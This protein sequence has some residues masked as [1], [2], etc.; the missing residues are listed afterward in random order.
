MCDNLEQ[1]TH[2]ELQEGLKSMYNKFMKVMQDFHDRK[3]IDTGFEE[4]SSA[5]DWAARRVDEP[6]KKKL[7]KFNMEL[8]KSDIS[9]LVGRKRLAKL[10]REFAPLLKSLKVGMKFEQEKKM[11]T[12]QQYVNEAYKRVWQTPSD[13]KNTP[14]QPN[15]YKNPSNPIIGWFSNKHNPAGGWGVFAL[16]KHD[17][18]WFKQKKVSTKNVFRVATDSNTS[19]VRFN[20]KTGTVAWLDNDHLLDTDEIKFQKATA[21]Q[22]FILTKD[23]RSNKETGMKRQDVPSA[24]LL[25]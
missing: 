8:A 1:I 6:T 18:A 20:F 12:F 10:E 25:Y 7:K 14:W 4:L 11:K 2:E 17:K 16:D 5:V 19:I 23:D 13:S 21:Y 15:G 22:K 24:R 3:N 9:T